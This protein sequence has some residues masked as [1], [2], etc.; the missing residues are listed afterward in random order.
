[1]NNEKLKVVH[2]MNQFFGQLG[3]EAEADKGFVVREGAV[4]PGM[5]LQKMLGEKAKV[6][7]TLICGDNYFSKDPEAAAIEGLKL[8]E[9]YKPDIF[10]AG[11]AFNAGRYGLACAAIC[12]IVIKQL[13]IPAITGMYEENPGVEAYRKNF[14]ICRV[15]N[16]ARDMLDGLGSMVKLAYRLVSK[17]KNE[18]LL[19]KENIPSP[20]EYNY[21]SRGILRNVF[22]ENNAA[23]RSIIKLLSKIKGDPFETEINLPI[24]EKIEPPKPIQDI[25]HCEIALA[26]DGGLVPKGNPDRFRS[27]ANTKWACYNLDTFIPEDFKSSDFYIA[28]N[29]YFQDAVLENPYRLVPVDIMRDLVK[30]G[31]IGKLHRD[32]FSTTGNG[33]VTKT[34]VSMG[35]EIAEEM[36][37]RGIGAVIFTGT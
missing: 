31:K 11:P 14:Y 18:Q 34:F 37:K 10:F 23:E 36:T 12:Q 16:S 27:V 32:F 33:G 13:R 20:S 1:M 28:H 21:F 24:I 19:T 22:V 6:S 4:G 9:A 25:S 29:G 26:S 15:G 2:Y 17:K 5:A 30:E 35:D 7:A 3:G 8:I